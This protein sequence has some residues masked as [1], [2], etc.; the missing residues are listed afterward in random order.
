MNRP[1]AGSICTSSTATT[2][3]LRPRN[4]KRLIATAARN[5][6]TM[7]TSTTSSVMPMLMPSAEKNEPSAR[8][9]VKLLS[10]P[11]IGKKVGMNDCRMIVGRKAEFTIQ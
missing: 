10:V 11:L 9:P 1:S 4:R 2:K 5:A 8:A 6:N 3:L 7:H